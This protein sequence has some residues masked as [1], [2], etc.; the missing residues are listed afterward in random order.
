MKMNKN[1]HMEATQFN[2][3]NKSQGKER[4]TKRTRLRA[5]RQ[6][7]NKRKDQRTRLPFF[8]IDVRFGARPKCITGCVYFAKTK[9]KKSRYGTWH[10]TRVKKERVLNGE[11]SQSTPYVV[12]WDLNNARSGY[13]HNWWPHISSIVPSK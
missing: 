11:K 9:Q 1:T 7:L 8:A 12:D 2:T 13:Q 10:V 4:D 3:R 5:A 6:N